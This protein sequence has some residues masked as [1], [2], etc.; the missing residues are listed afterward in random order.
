MTGTSKDPGDVQ[1]GYLAVAVDQHPGPAAR[2]DGVDA[3]IVTWREFGGN[4]RPQAAEGWTALGHLE[5][6]KGHGLTKVAKDSAHA[7]AIGVPMHW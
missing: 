3:Y 2:A 1:T 4:R 6:V 7:G 5:G